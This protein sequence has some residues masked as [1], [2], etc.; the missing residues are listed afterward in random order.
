MHE[1]CTI[2]KN[3]KLIEYSQNSYKITKNKPITIS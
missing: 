3:R 1:E 2:E